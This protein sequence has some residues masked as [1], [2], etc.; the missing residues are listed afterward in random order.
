MDSRCAGA[1]YPFGPRCEDEVTY[2]SPIGGL[3]TAC[4]EKAIES[5]RKGGTLLNILAAARGIGIEELVSKYVKI[6]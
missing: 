3:C 5:I 4:A 6:A 1:R 2:K